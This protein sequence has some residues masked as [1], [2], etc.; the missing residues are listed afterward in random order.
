MTLEVRHYS[1]MYQ[2][3]KRF[4]YRNMVTFARHFHA[5][6]DAKKIAVKEL[7]VGK[8]TLYNIHDVRQIMLAA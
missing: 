2:L 4:G 7:N 6:R 1:S 5:L 8:R 3:S